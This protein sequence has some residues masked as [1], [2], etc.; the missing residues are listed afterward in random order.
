MSRENSS[1]GVFVFSFTDRSSFEEV[2][3]VSFIS[4]EQAKKNF[5]N[6]TGDEFESILDVNPL[7]PSFVIKISPKLLNQSGIKAFAE[8]LKSTPG[9]TDVIYDYDFAGL[10]AVEFVESIRHKEKMKNIKQMTPVLVI[11]NQADAFTRDFSQI[12]HVK[13]LEFPLKEYTESLGQE[14]C[15][16]FEN[17]GFLP[18][19]L[20]VLRNDL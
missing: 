7:P 15:K 9:I 13:Y 10:N 14:E 12:D 1:G 8:S 16:G 2:N 20:Y 6:E 4:S 19:L 11:T 18:W 3:K 5:L 17:S